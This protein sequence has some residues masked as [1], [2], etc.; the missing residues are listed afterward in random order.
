MYGISAYTNIYL[1]N[2]GDVLAY[3]FFLLK[4]LRRL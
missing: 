4:C 2:N 3:G 1:I